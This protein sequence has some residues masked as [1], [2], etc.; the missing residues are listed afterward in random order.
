PRIDTFFQNWLTRHTRNPVSAKHIYNDFLQYMA[1]DAPSSGPGIVDIFSVLSDIQRDAIRFRRIQM[2]MGTTRFDEF[3]RRLHR[4]DVVV[5][6]PFLLALLGRDA[7]DAADLD[8][9]AKALESYLIRRMVCNLQT[10][11]YGMF[12]LELLDVLAKVPNG[13][14]AAPTIIKR[15]T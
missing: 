11:G 9:I 10:R 13:D 6:Y 5:F 4:L 2:P 15:L 3:L 7:T 8:E 1:K 14:R 12:A